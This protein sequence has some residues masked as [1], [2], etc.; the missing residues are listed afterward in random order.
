MRIVLL[1]FLVLFTVTPVVWAVIAFGW[2]GVEWL[3]GWPDSDGYRALGVAIIIAPIVALLSGLVAMGWFVQ[4][5]A[6]RESRN[7]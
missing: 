2:L 7:P 4:N 5:R 3:L 1:G 6:N